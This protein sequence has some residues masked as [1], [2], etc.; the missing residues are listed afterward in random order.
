MYVTYY[1]NDW[2]WLGASKSTKKPTFV[3][4]LQDF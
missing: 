2:S 4:S 3:N 1:V